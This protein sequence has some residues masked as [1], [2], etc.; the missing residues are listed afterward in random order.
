MDNNEQN[1]GSGASAGDMS[2][3]R[4]FDHPFSKVIRMWL[5]QGGLNPQEHEAETQEHAIQYS[6]WGGEGLSIVNRVYLVK[7]DGRLNAYYHLSV[8]LT[9]IRDIND[10][11]LL[12]WLLNW[13]STYPF[14]MRL[15]MSEEGLVTLEARGPCA[16]MDLEYYDVLL[17]GCISL[18]DDILKDLCLK[19]GARPFK[20]CISNSSN[21]AG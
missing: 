16:A 15:A 4:L 9:K 19:F 12:L 2:E 20:E 17:R 21:K 13:N 3:A 6:C 11:K 7:E 18:G 8:A 14:P 1:K 10:S 5:S